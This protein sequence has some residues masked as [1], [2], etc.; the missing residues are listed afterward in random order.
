MTRGLVPRD[1]EEHELGARLDVGESATVDLH[2]EQQRHEVVA[3]LR[4][5]DRD[6]MIDVRGELG[7]GPGEAL[8]ALV[9]VLGGVGALH[10]LVGPRGPLLEVLRRGAEQ[11]GDHAGGDGH[12][13]APDQVDDAIAGEQVVEK[14][15]AQCGAERLDAAELVGGDGAI[16]DP[17]DLPVPGLGDLVDELL[18]VGHDDARLAEAGVE[19]VDVLGGGE[20]VVE[21]RQEPHAVGILRDDLVGAQPHHLRIIRGCNQ[22]VEAHDNLLALHPSTL[23]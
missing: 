14:L 12:H 10:D 8:A 7:M 3:G 17:P 15:V 22:R 11:V 1:E 21:T 16:D 5:P 19:R 13:V 6:L 20:H 2:L 23:R 4:A 18:L 9:A